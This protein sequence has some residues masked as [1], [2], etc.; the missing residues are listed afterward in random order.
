MDI[1]KFTKK[2][3]YGNDYKDNKYK[4]LKLYEFQKDFLENLVTSDNI[5]ALKS[6]AMFMTTML[7]YYCAWSLLYG[8]N[9]NIGYIGPNEDMTKA[10]KKRIFDIVRNNEDRR[11]NIIK[12]SETVFELANG[13]TIEFIGNE[14]PSLTYKYNIIIGDELDVVGRNGNNLPFFFKNVQDSNTKKIFVS[15]YCPRISNEHPENNYFRYV[16][17]RRDDFKRII[18]HYSENPIY[19]TNRINTLKQTYHPRDW[20]VEMECNRSLYKDRATDDEQKVIK[21]DLEMTSDKYNHLANLA[22]E[23][24][25]SINAYVNKLINNEISKKYDD[26]E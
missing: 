25:Q 1:V 2:N 14:R 21:Y 20:E 9:V 23:E 22:K 7:S 13:N 3:N 6:R 24:R 17:E 15:S 4:K 5:V 16:L 18:L 26:V 11:N 8:E 12:Q 10:V 19:T